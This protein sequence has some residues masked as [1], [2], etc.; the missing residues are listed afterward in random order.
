MFQLQLFFAPLWRM[1]PRCSSAETQVCHRS[2]IIAATKHHTENKRSSNTNPTKNW[3]EHRSSKSVIISCYT[4]D[5]RRVTPNYKPGSIR[6]LIAPLVSLISSCLSWFWLSCL[7]CL[8]Y[9]FSETLTLFGFPRTCYPHARHFDYVLFYIIV[10][11][12]EI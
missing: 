2:Y 12:Y 3:D 5:I 11:C 1:G 10:S 6:V 9:L 4:Y 8:V 7:G